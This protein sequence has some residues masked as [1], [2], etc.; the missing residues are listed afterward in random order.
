MPGYCIF[1]M[2]TL[3]SLYRALS[4]ARFGAGGTEGSAGHFAEE[5]LHCCCAG[6]GRGKSLLCPQQAQSQLRSPLWHRSL[7]REA[8]LYPLRNLAE[9]TRK[10]S[11]EELHFGNDQGHKDLLSLRA[12]L[13]LNSFSQ[14]R[15]TP[16]S[17][18]FLKT[19]SSSGCGTGSYHG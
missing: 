8:S 18:S 5:F 10:L 15:E 16:C 1:P 6:T 2:R 9:R 4:P 7:G 13:L 11:R 14:L 19:S 12:C 17:D 3:S